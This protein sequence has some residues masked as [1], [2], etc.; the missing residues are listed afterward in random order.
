MA[1]VVGQQVRIDE[2]NQNGKN[3]TGKAANTDLYRGNTAG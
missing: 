3:E 2:A 1:R